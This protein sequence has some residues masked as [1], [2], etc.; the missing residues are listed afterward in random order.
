MRDRPPRRSGSVRAPTAST[1]LSA[2]PR[3][4]R[5]SLPKSTRWRAP[6]RPRLP[7]DG[8]GTLSGRLT[9]PRPAVGGLGPSRDDPGHGTL[10][11]VL[12]TPPGRLGRPPVGA[13]SL[14]HPA[15]I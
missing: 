1:S 12:S 13:V 11:G 3:T 10:S 8:G 4:T 5:A 2:H 6:S 9:V 7:H 14:R 15:S